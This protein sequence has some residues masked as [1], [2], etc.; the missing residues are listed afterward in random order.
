MRKKAYRKRMRQI[1]LS[2]K[3]HKF[4]TYFQ[5]KGH[6]VSHYWTLHPTSCPKHMQE[7]RKIGASG[8][9][10]SIIDVKTEVSHEEELQ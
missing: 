1:Q 3:V 10:E 7:E 8:T 4:C 5:K 9:A 2:N 6:D